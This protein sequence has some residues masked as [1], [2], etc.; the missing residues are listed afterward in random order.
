MKKP[1]SSDKVKE[2]TM[3]KS[4]TNSMDTDE[5]SKHDKNNIS[6]NP[7]VTTGKRTISKVNEMNVYE[8]LSRIE[9][10]MEEMEMAEGKAKDKTVSPTKSTKS[11]QQ[12]IVIED[13][14]MENETEEKE[15]PK[16]HI[17]MSKNPVQG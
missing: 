1:V 10:K 16:Q 9:I 6:S 11:D 13:K 4:P 5:T 14:D 15:A 7:T 3:A 8:G 12:V 17:A 2:I